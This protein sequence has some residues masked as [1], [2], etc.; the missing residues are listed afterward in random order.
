[1]CYLYDISEQEVWSS[2]H[3]IRIKNVNDKLKNYF[4]EDYKKM[5][6]KVIKLFQVFS[7]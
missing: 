3:I 6:K 4:N 5:I 1:M 7:R 2:V